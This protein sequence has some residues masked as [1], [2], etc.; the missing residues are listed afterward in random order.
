MNSMPRL[1]GM[2]ATTASTAGWI[3][4]ADGG[5]QCMFCGQPAWHFQPLASSGGLNAPKRLWWCRP[6][7]TTWVA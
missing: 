4:A 3:E 7:E 5:P 6:C 2:H 1:E